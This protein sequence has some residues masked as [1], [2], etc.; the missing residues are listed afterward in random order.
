VEDLRVDSWNELNDV[1]TEG[2]WDAGIGRRRSRFAFRGTGDD[3]TDLRT[4]LAR[5]GGTFAGVERNLTRN[6]RKYAERHA[7]RNDST[8]SWLSLAQ[9]HGLPTRLL[10]WTYSPLVAAHFATA[11]VERYHLDGA[12][13]CV[14]FVQAHRHLPDGMRTLVEAEGSEV[15][16]VE[17]LGA[18]TDTL[19]EFDRLADEPFVA[20]FEPPS[21][22]ERILSQ[23]ALFSV[24]SDPTARFDAWLDRHPDVTARRVVIPADLKW[25]VRDRLDMAGVNERTLFPGLDG[26]SRWLARYYAPRGHDGRPVP[27]DRE[28]GEDGSASRFH[29]LD[30]G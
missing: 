27:A 20:F 6:F 3:S 9:H 10:D 16:T 15:F 25:E 18:A 29:H 24:L 23:W 4:S 28:P 5:L 12:V 17:M 1:L 21:F 13:W 2:S 14:N 7:F 22:D 11:N 26:L 30:A 8:W 19:E